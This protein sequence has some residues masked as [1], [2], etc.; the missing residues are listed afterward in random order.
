MNIGLRAFFVIADGLQR[1]VGKFTIFCATRVLLCNLNVSQ[2][3]LIAL[4]IAKSRVTWLACNICCHA[5]EH[6][7]M[8]LFACVVAYWM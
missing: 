3:V 7:I 4:I 8:Q 6:K 5:I 1:K 2:V